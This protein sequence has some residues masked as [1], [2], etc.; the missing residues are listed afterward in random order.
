MEISR[1]GVK[2]ELQ[3][4]ASATPTAMQDPSCI[5]NLHHN[6]WPCWILNPLRPEIKPASSW[7]LVRFLSAKPPGEL[8]LRYFNSPNN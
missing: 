1:L 7:T 3:P 6:S 2:W 4:P 5:C 8:P